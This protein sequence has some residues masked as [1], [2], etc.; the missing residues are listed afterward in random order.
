MRNTIK[1]EVGKTYYGYGEVRGV[2]FT[3]LK[4][5][6]DTCIFKRSDDW[7]E[8][9]V[10]QRQKEQTRVINGKERSFI[11]KELYPYGDSWNGKCVASYEKALKIFNHKIL[12]EFAQIFTHAT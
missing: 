10:I 8:V 1:F 9:V 11:K 5:D 3:L 2:D 7:Y 12:Q 6:S 4:R